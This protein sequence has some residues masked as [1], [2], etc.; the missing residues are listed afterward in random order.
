MTS[1]ERTHY[2]SSGLV[3]H[4]SIGDD[5]DRA[6]PL[7]GLAAGQGA[8]SKYVEADASYSQ[9]LAMYESVGNEVG[10]AHSLIGLGHVKSRLSTWKESRRT[11]KR[12]RSVERTPFW[13]SVKADSIKLGT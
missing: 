10:R 3:I 6:N 12:Y 13:G 9:A 11:S 5:L 2:L 4:G 8:Q 7:L 1:A